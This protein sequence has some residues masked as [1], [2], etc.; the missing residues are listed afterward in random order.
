VNAVIVRWHCEICCNLTSCLRDLSKLGGLTVLELG[1]LLD[2]L[3]YV[4]PGGLELLNMPE[5]TLRCCEGRNRVLL[6]EHIS[7][8]H[9]GQLTEAHGFLKFLGRDMHGLPYLPFLGFLAGFDPP[10]LVTGFASALPLGAAGREFPPRADWADC[11][12]LTRAAIACIWAAGL[13]TG[14]RGGIM[15]GLIPPRWRAARSA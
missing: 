9:L 8:L 12:S 14:R 3:L 7:C 15:P 1:V 5:S 2:V 13:A 11:A 4:L 6:R 10:L